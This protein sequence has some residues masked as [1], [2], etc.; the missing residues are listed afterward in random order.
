MS[1]VDGNPR[2]VL[3]SERH[4]MAHG[5]RKRLLWLQQNYWITM[6]ALHPNR[7]CLSHFALL[8]LQGVKEMHT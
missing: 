4:D 2:M 3:N 1:K 8:W 5:H 7:F 6:I